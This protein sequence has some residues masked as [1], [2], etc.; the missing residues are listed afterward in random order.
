MRDW[1]ASIRTWEKNK[2]SKT[3]YEEKRIKEWQEAGEKFLRGE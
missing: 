2:S 3:S 1:K